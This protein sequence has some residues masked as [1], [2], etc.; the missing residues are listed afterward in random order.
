M[1][2]NVNIWKIIKLDKLSQE[3]FSFLN[4]MNYHNI[5]IKHNAYKIILIQNNEIDGFRYFVWSKEV[6]N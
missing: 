5:L 4:S 3:T 2:L 1:S 6:C